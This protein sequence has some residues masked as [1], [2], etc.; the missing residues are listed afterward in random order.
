MGC[1]SRTKPTGMKDEEWAVLEKKARSLIRLCLADS[2]L[3]NIFEE[4]ATSLWKKLGVLFQAN[5]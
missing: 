3:F 5:P 2:V 1:A 4:T